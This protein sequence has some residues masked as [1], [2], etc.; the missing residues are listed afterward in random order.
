MLR[1]LRGLAPLVLALAGMHA[2]A[3][4]DT[5]IRE[6][7]HGERSLDDFARAFFGQH[8]GPRYP[9]LARIDNSDERLN[10]VAHPRAK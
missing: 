2:T 7:S 3:G 8:D 1:T 9:H 4:A 5:R 6:L 10:D